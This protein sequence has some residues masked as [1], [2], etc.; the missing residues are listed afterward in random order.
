MTLRQGLAQDVTGAWTVLDDSS[1]LPL[2]SDVPSRCVSY[3]LGANASSRVVSERAQNRA[4]GCTLKGNTL[5]ASRFRMHGLSMTR[6]GKSKTLAEP[7]KYCCPRAPSKNSTHSG[8]ES[9]WLPVSSSV[10]EPH[11]LLF[12]VMMNHCRT[13]PTRAIDLASIEAVQC[14][15]QLFKHAASACGLRCLVCGQI[16]KHVGL[17]SFK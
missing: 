16:R 2:T 11:L 10:R 5:D 6:V 1:L 3:A 4:A 7:R 8:I 14:Q 9:Q 12:C 15:H 13:I 17:D